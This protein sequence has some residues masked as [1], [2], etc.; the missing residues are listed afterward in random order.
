MINAKEELERVLKSLNYNY[1]NIKCYNIRHR[2]C[3]SK[4]QL[5]SIKGKDINALKEKMNFNYDNGFGTQELYGIILFD[6]NSWLERY[7]Y[8]GSEEWKYIKPLNCN[9]VIEYNI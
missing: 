1:N 8:D 5:L 3:C 7:E 9:D 6:D 2:K 4:N